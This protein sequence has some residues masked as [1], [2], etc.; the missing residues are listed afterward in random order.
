MLHGA[1]GDVARALCIPKQ[2][3]LVNPELRI[4]WAVEPRS[5]QLLE[6]LEGLD[7]RIIFE[8]NKGLRGYIEFVSK[9]REFNADVCLD[10]QRHFKSGITS[11]LSGA[12]VR[13]GFH[14]R[15][16]KEFNWVF[17]N[18]RLEYRRNAPKYLHYEDFLR[19][20]GAAFPEASYRN[21]EH[22]QIVY[23]MTGS[24][25]ESRYW[26][27]ERWVDLATRV[28]RDFGLKVCL[29]GSKEE[30]NY[31]ERIKAQCSLGGVE[32]LSGTYRLSE[33]QQVF[34]TCAACV[35]IDSGPMHI[36]SSAGAHVISLWGP[37]NWRRSEPMNN[38]DSMLISPA[39][40]RGCFRRK[41]PGLDNLCMR[42][43]PV[44]AVAAHLEMI[45][46]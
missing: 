44:E 10:L 33:L 24:T 30:W 32:N 2:L 18:K 11:F 16:S 19:E 41:C 42:S 13:Y 46:K 23:F 21:K 26:P 15:N 12:K 35:S 4:A 36:A 38:H 39:A 5:M 43:I 27:V 14:R 37:T 25:W 17:N 40:C 3:K 20:F 29:L 22:D 7:K 31:N 28:K 34:S 6:S 8:R 9:L 45:L 1:I